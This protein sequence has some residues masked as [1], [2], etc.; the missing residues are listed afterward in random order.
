LDPVRSRKGEVWRKDTH[1]DKRSAVKGDRL[2]NDLWIRSEPLLPQ[3]IS[4]QGDL[5]AAF[6]VFLLQE[7]A[8]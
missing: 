7:I 1:N 8:A 6:I 2:S 5:V 3:C 4:E